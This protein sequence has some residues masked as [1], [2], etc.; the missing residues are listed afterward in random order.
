MSELGRLLAETRAAKELSLADVEVA[1]RIRQRYLDALE[2][3]A[4]G[5]LPRGAVARGFLRT[6]ARFLG[7]D[8]DEAIYLF[9]LEGGD[10][11]DDVIIAE[12]GQ[13]RLADYRPLEVELLDTRF[14]WSWLRWVLAAVLIIAIG[15]GGW[16]L[17]GRNLDFHPIAWLSSLG[18]E[19]TATPTPGPT[20]TPW[21]VTATMQPTATDTPVLP[22]PTSDILPLPTPTLEPTATPTPRPTATP[23]RVSSIALDMFVVQNS[24]LRVIVDD[25]IVEEALLETDAVR[26]WDAAQSIFIRTGNAGGISLILNGEDLGI[27]G[28]V[29]EVL[30]RQWVVDGGFAAEG[31]DATVVPG[32]GPEITPTPAG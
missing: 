26:S 27:M 9:E 21:G 15:G 19:A 8:V 30:E 28:E 20:N 5:D 24:W 7:L 10:Y 25:E 6:Y 2:V 32:P 22:T 13:P 11:G 16:W 3:G 29:G 18:P 14:D 1:T 4:F 12:P 17:L 31:L 23:E